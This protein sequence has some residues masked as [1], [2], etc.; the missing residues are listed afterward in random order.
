MKEINIY[1]IYIYIYIYIYICIYDINVYFFHAE[2]NANS[3]NRSYKIA[4]K[5]R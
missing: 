1:I 3:Y 5:N 2:H 4:K